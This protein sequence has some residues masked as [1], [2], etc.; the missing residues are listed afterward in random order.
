MFSI[1][2]FTFNP[3]AENTYILYNESSS[4]IIIDPGCYSSDE[5]KELFDF[6]QKN[7]LEP[8][9]L[10]QTHCHLDHVFG[11]ARMCETYQLKPYLHKDEYEIYSKA[12]LIANSYGLRMDDL[13][14]QVTYYTESA[15]INLDSDVLEIVHTPGH[16]PGSVS[17]I[18]HRQEFVIAGD[19]LFRES[20]G[21]TDLPGGDFE[22]LK[23][24]IH[25]QLFNLPD[26]Y[27]VYCGHGISTEIG[28][29]KR[30][31]PFVGL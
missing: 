23:H 4:C 29:E 24:S 19:V 27:N 16:S 30:N 3:F 6:I 13:P 21:R 14:T 25:T 2:T 8:K 7:Q 18:C 9:Y 5:A 22:M 12:A 28:Y 11:T 20:I 31:N 17:F 15:R 10:L 26:G 1:K